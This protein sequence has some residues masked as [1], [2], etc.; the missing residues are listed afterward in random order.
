MVLDVIGADARDDWQPRLA[1]AFERLLNAPF[2]REGRIDPFRFFVLE[3]GPGF[4]L[5]L[6]YDHFIA[7]G[8][9]IV[10]LLNDV[11][12]RYAGRANEDPPPERYPPT[13]ARLFARHPLQFLRGI[14]RMPAMVRSC[15]RAVRPYYREIEDGHNGFALYAL[16]AEEF[17]SLRR[18]A[19]HWGVTLNDLLLALLLLAQD[20]RTPERHGADR[21]NELA[22]ASIMNL[23]D[24]HGI[25]IRDTFGQFLSSFRLSHPVPPE[26]ALRSVAQDVH[27]ATLAI[28]RD[29]L[30]LVTLFAMYIDRMIGRY[31]SRRQRM[32]VYAKTYPVGAGIS[33]LDVNG[34]WRAEGAEAA[35]LYVRGVP[36]GPLAPIVVAVTTSGDLLHAG[37][38]YRTTAVGPEEIARIWSEV[39]DRIRALN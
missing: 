28:K 13:H 36:T 35:P 17:A 25:R 23:R 10:A 4:F 31:Q 26:V 29:R 22:V 8:D 33:L 6:A 7:G 38:S 16:D 11:V 32:L 2:A 20:A 9:S 24:A 3:S 19:K 18:T 12:D 39:I 37:I 30:Y 14:A 34:L 15:R 27:A 21:R 1:G 5:G